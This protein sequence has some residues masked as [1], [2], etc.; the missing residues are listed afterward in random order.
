MQHYL[1]PTIINILRDFN[2]AISFAIQKGILPNRKILLQCP[3]CYCIM[4]F[5]FSTNAWKCH[6]HDCQTTRSQ[7]FPL[8][9][10]SHSFQNYL[11]C[12]LLFSSDI[13]IGNAEILFPIS[14]Q[15]LQSYYRYFRRRI[16]KKYIDEIHT[17]KLSFH[18]QIDESLFSK[19]KYERGRIKPQ[20]WVFGA[21]DDNPGGRVYM[22]SVE[23][24]DEQNLLPIIQSW[25]PNGSIIYSDSWPAYRNL[26]NYGFMHCTV[27]H[28]E[29]F[30]NHD[31][32]A[33]TQRIEALWHQCKVFLETHSYNKGSWLDYYIGEWCFRYNHHNNTDEI[34]KAIIS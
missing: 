17:Q 33:N 1:A 16:F 6:N 29:N 7:F 24:R 20:R 12:L 30:I 9:T 31:T 15:T 34:M 2:Y 10:N 4:S 21:C 8:E 19:R 28:S 14:N 23:K 26:N 3:K 22:V 5:Y 32:F 18:V 27:N 13:T 11:I 25:C